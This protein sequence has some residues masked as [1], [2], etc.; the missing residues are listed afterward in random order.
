MLKI[1]LKHA[2][3]REL[4]SRMRYNEHTEVV[5]LL[6]TVKILSTYFT[7]Q[8][9]LEDVLNMTRKADRTQ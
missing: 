5:D 3:R 1:A 7:K 9:F 2:G 4:N 8:K 6:N